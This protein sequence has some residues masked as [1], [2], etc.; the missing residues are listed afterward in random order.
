[1]KFTGSNFV[2]SGLGLT[3]TVRADGA[4]T[5]TLVFDQQQQGP[6]GIVHGGALAAVLDEAMTAAV[7]EAGEPA[8]TA[9][10][11]IQYRAPLRTGQVATVT[12]RLEKA[13]GRKRLLHATVHDAAGTLCAEADGLFVLMRFEPPS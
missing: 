9:S 6:P 12:G 2:G 1:M 7:F 13:D 11:T 5:G 3:F 4:M 10:L 8:F